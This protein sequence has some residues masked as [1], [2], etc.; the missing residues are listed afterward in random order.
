MANGARR[1]VV[2]KE[3]RSWFQTAYLVF[4]V[5]FRPNRNSRIIEPP[6]NPEAQARPF[7]LLRNLRR[8]V[9]GEGGALEM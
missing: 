8:V 3:G 5:L 2:Q 4:I 9:G 6:M 7:T 1:G